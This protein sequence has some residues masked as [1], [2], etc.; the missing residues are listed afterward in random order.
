MLSDKDIK[1]SLENKEI[2]ILKI[3]Y[4][5]QRTKGL[6]VIRQRHKNITRK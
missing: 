6:N 4:D 2:K 1:I 5:I 3:G